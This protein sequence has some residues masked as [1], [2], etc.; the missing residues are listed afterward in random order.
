MAPSFAPQDWAT[1]ASRLHGKLIRP[2]AADYV[3]AARLYNPRF[4]ASSRPAAIARCAGAADVQACVRFAAD[5]GT[6]FAVRCGGHSYGGWSTSRG[7]VIDVSGI[8]S[9]TV[10]GGAGTARIGAGARLVDVY[11]ALAAKGVALAAGSCPTVGM[12]GLTLGGGVG[13]LSRAWGLTCDAVTGVE[14]VTADGQLRLVDARRDPDLFWAL[15]GGGGSFG[16]VTAWT[17]STRPAPS[18]HTFFLAWDFAR[19]PEVL[20]AWQRWAPRTDPKLWS[21]CKLLADPG[22]DRIRATVSGT[23]IGHAS[24]LDGQLNPLL[25]QT[26]A[27]ANRQTNSLTYAKAMLWEAGCASQDAAQCESVALSL[28]KRQPF[29]ATSSIAAAELPPAAIEAAVAQTR[30]GMNIANM[31]EGGVSFDVLGGAVA[32]VAPD[33]TAFVHRTAMATVQYTATWQDAG[34][35]PAPFDAYVRGFRAA[36]APWLGSAAYVN[37][38]DPTIDR[39]GPAYWGDNYTRLQQVKRA[40][41]PS[42]LFAFGQSVQP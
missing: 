16:A 13:V 4:D 28:A 10:D 30:A 40:V 36:M 20:T 34:A 2:G 41:D 25:T 42:A 35:A 39:Y 5:T 19:A 3:G 7:L 12:T 29:A 9:V 27:P 32:Q 24:G 33:A 18:V 23:W 1:L 31:V 37:Y 8:D 14:I 38:A 15:R 21:T 26:G 11:A 22:R 17:V 6:P